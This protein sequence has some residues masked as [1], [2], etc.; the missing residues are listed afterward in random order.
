MFLIVSFASSLTTPGPSSVVKLLEH[1]PLTVGSLGKRHAQLEELDQSGRKVLEPHIVVRGILLHELLELA[2]LDEC[3][4]GR[5]HH[6]R[7]GLLVLILFPRQLSAFFPRWSC[8]LS[9]RLTC[10]GPL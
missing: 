2:V 5:Q 6:Q 8:R 3:H 9:P 7:L 10:F 1:P 4:I